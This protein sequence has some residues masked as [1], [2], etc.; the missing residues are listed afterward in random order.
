MEV[1]DLARQTAPSVTSF[2]EL[3][4]CGTVV[5]A[6]PSGG[7]KKLFSEVLSGKKNSEWH[8]LTEKPNYNKTAEETKKLL[9][10][11]IYPFNMKIGIRRSKA[12]R[13]ATF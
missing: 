9:R 4:S 10:I 12:S 1:Y 13:M 6:P 3:N 7:K 11:K 8:R 2:T 5:T